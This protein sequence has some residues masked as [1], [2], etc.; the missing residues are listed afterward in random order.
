MSAGLA[1]RFALDLQKQHQFDVGGA[2][3]WVSTMS[4]GSVWQ[5]PTSLVVTLEALLTAVVVGVTETVVKP[6]IAYS[7]HVNALASWES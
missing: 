7:A 6:P 1:D 2:C 3:T 4:C 5:M